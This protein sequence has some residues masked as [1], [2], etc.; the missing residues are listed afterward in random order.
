[1]H[2]EYDSEK[3]SLHC[4][5]LIIL[6]YTV[7]PEF[8]AKPLFSRTVLKDIFV[9]LQI[10]DKGRFTYIIKQKSNSAIL[11]GFYFHKTSHMQSFAKIKASRKLPNL[12]YIC[13]AIKFFA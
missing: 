13:K 10:C 7:N 12:Q 8:F 11:Q 5:Q 3:T 9:M 4:G 6:L 2:K 1:M